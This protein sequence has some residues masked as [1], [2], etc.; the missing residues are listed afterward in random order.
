MT[1]QDY[2]SVM[3]LMKKTSGVTVREADSREATGRYLIRNPGLSFV[4][5]LNGDLVGCVMCGHDGIF[6]WPGGSA[7]LTFDK[8]RVNNFLSLRLHTT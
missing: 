7:A 5:E 1:I 6:P 3:D 8:K 2:D 4:A